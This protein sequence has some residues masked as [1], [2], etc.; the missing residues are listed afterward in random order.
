MLI[1]FPLMSVDEFA[2]YAV[3]CGI[4]TNKEIV[5]LFLYLIRNKKP[6]IDIIDTPRKF[7]SSNKF[8]VNRFQG[9]QIKCD[10]RRYYR[11]GD[12]IK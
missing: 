7:F 12:R 2:I 8:F 10:Y 4:F 11:T 1:R 6:S 9:I 3:Q 5:T